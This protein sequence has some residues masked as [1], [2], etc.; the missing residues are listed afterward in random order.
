MIN[1]KLYEVLYN[2]G[3]TNCVRGWHQMPAF[4]NRQRV[5]WNITFRISLFLE[6]I[7]YAISVLSVAQ[8]CEGLKSKP[9]LKLQ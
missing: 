8:A 7:I 1:N 6:V 5:S 4:T 3:N 9:V 2:S